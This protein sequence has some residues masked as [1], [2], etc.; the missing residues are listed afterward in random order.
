MLDAIV[1][2]VAAFALLIAA[3]VAPANADPDK[4][5]I[6]IIHNSGQ[7]PFY[8]GVERGYFA[9]EGLDASLLAFDAAVPVA[10]AAASGD[11]DFGSAGGTGALYN[12]AGQGVLKLIGGNTHEAP[13]FQL[14]GLVVADGAYEAGLTRAQDLTGR[15]VAV[16][17]TGGG[18][19]YALALLADKYGVDLKTVRI[20]PLQ[21][22]PNIASALTGGQADAAMLNA[23][24]ATPLLQRGTVKLIAW[25]GD[26]TPY[27]A[28]V[29]FTS[30][31][32]ADTRRSVVERFLNAYRKAA[33]DYAAAFVGADGKRTNGPTAPEIAKII[34]KYSGLTPEQVA[35]GI[36]YD[37]PDARLDEKDVLNQIAWFRSQGMVKNDF[38]ARSVI[39]PRYAVPLP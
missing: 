25:S 12:L 19:H 34:A 8:I 20:L 15:A 18:Y 22:I 33:H 36:A 27:Q 16:T 1:K 5:K 30:T 14:F 32:N 17:Q 38:E 23:T 24:A 37:D 29:I 7:A 3:S 35:L 11:I 21:A 39:D 2:L 6:G 10:V 28:V 31:R 4:I 9:A 13:S 26:E